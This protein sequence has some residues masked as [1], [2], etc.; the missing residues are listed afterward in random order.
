[1]KYL[2]H[3]LET[4]VYSHSNICNIQIYFCNVYMKYLQYKSETL[5]TY[6]YIH[7]NICNIHMKHLKHTSNIGLQHTYIVIATSQIYFCN[8]RCNTKKSETPEIFETRRRRR[9]QPT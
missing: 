5:E 6:V 3:V 9:P 4:L 1:V 7:R 2:K 8:I